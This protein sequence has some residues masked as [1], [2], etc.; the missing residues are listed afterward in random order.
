MKKYIKY[1]IKEVKFFNILYRELLHLITIP[2]YILNFKKANPRINVEAVNKVVFIAH[3]DDEIVSMGHFLQSTSN[4]LVIC[5]TNGGN[6]RRLKEFIAS[7]NTLG[8]QYQIWNFKDAID[9]EWN[10]KKASKKIR[11]ILSIKKDW[12]MVISHNIE[13]DYGHFQHK[14]V[15]KLVR[16][17]YDKDNFYCPVVNKDLFDERNKLLN[18]ESIKKIHMFKEHYKSQL[19]ILNLYENYFRYEKIEKERGSI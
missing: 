17:N 6:V 1:M 10:E 9:F 14:Q 19:H 18:K 11:K 16:K 15:Y 12:N 8:A 4:V 5:M 13:G 2:F 3:P 7:M